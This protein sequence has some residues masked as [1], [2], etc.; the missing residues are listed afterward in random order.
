M[1][2][3]LSTLRVVDLTGSIAGNYCSRLFQDFGATVTLAEPDGGSPVRR[4]A[5][6][7]GEGRSLVFR[8][9]NAGKRIVE[10]PEDRAGLSALIAGHDVLLVPAGLEPALRDIADERSICI[11]V[12][13]FGSDGPYADWQGNEMVFQALSGMMS[14]NGQAGREP[15]YGVGNRASYAA[16]VAAYLTAM[17]AL[18]AREGDG[19]GQS[20]HVEVAETAAAMSFPYVLQY[21]Y[22]GTDRRRGDQEIPAGQVLCRGTWVCIWIYPH[23][24]AAMCEAI[25][26]PELLQDARF[27]ETADRMRNWAE[28]FRL[29]QDRLRDADAEEVVARL[30]SAQVISACAYRPSELLGNPHL[31]AR[32]YWEGPDPDGHPRLGP[33]VRFSRTPRA[34]WESGETTEAAE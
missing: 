13:A 3:A 2:S 12:S 21:A 32:R 16:G 34:R 33:P 1:N 11:E 22:N 26:M 20:G 24:F 14:N 5:P 10:L 27:A 8:H 28:M 4:A 6:L 18:Y 23:R 29:I 15:L 25:D 31:K 17:T 9:L 7:D 19:K 30:Q